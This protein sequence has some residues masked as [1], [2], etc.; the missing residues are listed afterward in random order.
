MHLG[1]E[2]IQVLPK[3]DDQSKGG[4]QI[5]EEK[6]AS[7]ASNLM[8]MLAYAYNIKI[9]TLDLAHIGAQ[10]GNWFEWLTFLFASEM[11]RQLQLG[12][13]R[14]YVQRDETLALIRGKWN[15]S[16]QFTQHPML[17]DRFDVRYAEFTANTP[18]NQILLAATRELMQLTVDPVNYRL[19]HATYVALIAAGCNGQASLSNNYP[20]LVHFTRLEDRFRTAYLLADLF[21]RGKVTNIFQGRKAYHAFMFDMNELFEQFV[22]GF[23]NRHKRAIFGDESETTRVVP[24]ARQHRVPFLSRHPGNQ[25]L[26]NLKPD[27][28]L[29]QNGQLKLIGDTKYKQLDP[30]KKNRNITESDSYQMLAY[31]T[32]Y[33]CQHVC[34]IYPQ[35]YSFPLQE[36]FRITNHPAR[37][38]IATINLHQPLEKP[39]G[40]IRE[41]TNLF[42]NIFS[43]VNHAQV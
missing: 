38:R 14:S 31:A 9:H 8:V 39:D 17:V 34:L 36:S 20:E 12:V 26:I 35:V 22:A 5:E 7:A 25:E 23:L 41:F 16:H 28:L 21:L 37:L 29:F 3:I 18:L 30:A 19:L 6:I 15:L 11:Q 40:L 42:S 4:H 2:S 24:Q 1:A 33:Q 10:R 13:H 27:L 32:A 43:E